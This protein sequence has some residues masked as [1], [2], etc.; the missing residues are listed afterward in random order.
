MNLAKF[1]QAQSQLADAE[2]RADLTEQ[3]LAKTKVKARGASAALEV[4]F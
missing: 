4:I 2:E 3:A 1:R